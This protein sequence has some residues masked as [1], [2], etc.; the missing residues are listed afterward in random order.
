VFLFLK[1]LNSG[2]GSVS[3]LARSKIPGG[4]GLSMSGFERLE[5]FVASTAHAAARLQ[6]VATIGTAAARKK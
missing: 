5:P 3:V 1:I 2:G 6:A 4:E